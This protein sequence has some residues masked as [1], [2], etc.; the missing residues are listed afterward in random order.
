MDRGSIKYQSVVVGRLTLV[1]N[2][3]PSTI[4]VLT[5]ALPANLYFASVPAANAPSLGNTRST[6]AGHGLP[7]PLNTSK[8][9]VVSFNALLLPAFNKPP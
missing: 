3:Q 7:K 2:T 8:N 9:S 1:V 6:L 4:G 5:E